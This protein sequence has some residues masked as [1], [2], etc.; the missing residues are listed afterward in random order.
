MRFFAFALLLSC[1]SFEHRNQ[2]RTL[3]SQ[4]IRA[5]NE[6]TPDF[7]N[8][9]RKHE[10]FSALKQER[11]RVEVQL[12]IGSNGKVERFQIDSKPYPN[13]FVD[14]MFQ[15]AESVDFPKLDKGETVELVQPFIF[16]K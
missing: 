3:Q 8:C 10:L 2:E 1:S 7:A 13:Q 14:C 9:A 12:N 16:S 4:M 15:V 5:L 6:K 11:V